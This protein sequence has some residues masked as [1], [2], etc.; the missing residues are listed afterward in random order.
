MDSLLVLYTL[1][2]YLLL[3][4]KSDILIQPVNDIEIYSIDISSLVTSCF[5]HN[6]II[7]N[8][9]NHANISKEAIFDVDL[10]KTAFITNFTIFMFS[11][12]IVLSRQCLPFL[13]QPFFSWMPHT[14]VKWS[15]ESTEAVS[16]D[17]EEAGA[18]HQ[19]RAHPQWLL[20]PATNDLVSGAEQTEGCLAVAELDRAEPEKLSGTVCPGPVQSNCRTSAGKEKESCYMKPVVNALKSLEALC[21][22]PS[23]DVFVEVMMDC[24]SVDVNYPGNGLPLHREDPESAESGDTGMLTS[25]HFSVRRSQDTRAPVSSATTTVLDLPYSCVIHASSV[26]CTRLTLQNIGIDFS[27]AIPE[28]YGSKILTPVAF[29]SL[30][31]NVSFKPLLEQ[32]HSCANCD[33][34]VLDGDFTVTYDVNRETPGNIL[35]PWRIQENAKLAIQGKYTLYCLGFGYGVDYSFLEKLALENS[36]IAYRIYEDSDAVLQLQGFYNEIANPTLLDIEM[37]YSKNATS[38]VTQNIFKQYFDGSEIVVAGQITDNNLNSLTAEGALK[39][40]AI[41]VGISTINNKAQKQVQKVSSKLEHECQSAHFSLPAPAQNTP[42]YFPRNWVDSDPHFVISVPRKNDALCFN[43]QEE[44]GVILNL[45]EDRELGIAVN[46]ELIGDNTTGNNLIS[47]ETYF[48]RLGIVNKAM[49]LQIEVMTETITIIR[50]INRTTFSW[51][52]IGSINSDGLNL[53]IYENNQLKFS[54]GEGATFVIIMHKV[55][56]DHLHRDFLGFYTLDD[57]KFS[58]RVHGLLGQFFYGIDYDIFNIHP[59]SDPNKPD[60]TM[61]VKDKL[62]I[63]TRGT[64]RDYMDGSTDDKVSCWFVHFNGEG[65]I[66]GSH[67]DYIVEDIFK[68]A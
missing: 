61:K 22:E 4:V 26:C 66:D 57:D 54:F 11:L 35:N 65:L 36:G 27:F 24:V 28:K 32:Q 17:G 23:K 39:Y 46:G 59:T 21:N 60:A 48:G 33:T 2:F 12:I 40:N 37:K 13:W 64:Q 19:N 7:S 67:T 58:K 34:T 41:L 62:I 6:V 52:D 47:N 15:G 43:I 10:P 5:A 53:A 8:A 45:I 30:P 25:A 9:V 50:G 29:F 42:S 55:L 1:S 51:L 16:T 14:V 20:T 3:P 56:K 44:P 31:G 38:N 63:V 18:V 68:F 49:N